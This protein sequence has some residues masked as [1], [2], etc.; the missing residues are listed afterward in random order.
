MFASTTAVATKKKNVMKIF[1]NA[2]YQSKKNLYNAFNL[3]RVTLL[4]STLSRL[5]K[6]NL[7]NVTQKLS[8][9]FTGGNDSV[10]FFLDN[11]GHFIIFFPLSKKM[12]F[13][14]DI[15]F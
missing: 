5:I 11:E 12:D 13:K 2:N 3:L 6:A 7:F 9:F 15:K 8:I 14:K 10:Y 4:S 1:S